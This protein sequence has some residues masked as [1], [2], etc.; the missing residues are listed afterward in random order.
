MTAGKKVRLSVDISDQLNET[1][2]D[3][4]SQTRSTKSEVLRRA[5]ALMEV[6]VQAK[7][8]GQRLGLANKDQPLATEIVGL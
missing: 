1:L 2:Q 4:A 8:R 5:I 3:L 6:A 7:E